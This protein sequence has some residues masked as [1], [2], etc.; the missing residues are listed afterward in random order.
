MLCTKPKKE[1]IIKNSP[2]DY[3]R[4]TE[5]INKLQTKN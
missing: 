2:T 5:I 4:Q 3:I 1:L